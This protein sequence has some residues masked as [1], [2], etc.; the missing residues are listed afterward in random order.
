MPSPLLLLL[1]RSAILRFALALPP[2]T[3]SATMPQSTLSRP[4]FLTRLPVLLHWT[5]RHQV[6]T[7]P[8]LRLCQLMNSLR[9]PAFKLMSTQLYPSLPG[10][11]NLLRPLIPLLCQLSL[12][13]LVVLP[14]AHLLAPT[15]FTVFSNPSNPPWLTSLDFA[16]VL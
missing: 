7:S 15:M 2:T 10:L 12:L 5:Q 3:P 13:W 1:I 11:K 4:L 9:H 16:L 6:P 14:M 8:I